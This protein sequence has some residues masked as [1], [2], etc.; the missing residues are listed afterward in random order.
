MVG[1]APVWLGEH[2]DFARQIVRIPVDGLNSQQLKAAV[3]E[4]IANS[5]KAGSRN[6]SKGEDVQDVI[7]KQFLEEF[8]NL[9][10]GLEP[11]NP[12]TYSMAATYEI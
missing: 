3:C 6:N 1:S 12:R 10:L 4:I 5:I 8:P 11:V 2:I 7:L 9:E